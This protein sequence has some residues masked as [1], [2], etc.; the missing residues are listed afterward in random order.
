MT[1]NRPPDYELQRVVRAANELQLEFRLAR[2]R[3]LRELRTD[4]S[5]H[6]G[7]LTRWRRAILRLPREWRAPLDRGRRPGLGAPPPTTQLITEVTCRLA[8]GSLGHV[9]IIRASDDEWVAEC[10]RA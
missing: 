4:M 3:Q 10:V 5:A 2:R 9:A 8:D 6:A 1:F 7:R